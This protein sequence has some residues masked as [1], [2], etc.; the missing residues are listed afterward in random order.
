M[1]ILEVSHRGGVFDKIIKEA[2]EDLRSV[3]SIPSNYKVIFF[4]GGGTAQFA[5]VPLNLLGPSNVPPDYLITG[6]WSQ[7]AYNEAKLYCAPQAACDS[8]NSQF[9]TIPPS[10]SWVQNPKAPYI[11]YC[12]NETV[13]GIEFSGIPSTLPGVPLVVDM[14]S[15][16]LS[17]PVDVSKFGAIYAGAQKNC[18]MSG[19]T[20]VIVREDLLDI[21][22]PHP[23][24]TILNWKKNSSLGSC[25]NTPPTMAIYVAGLVFK[26]ILKEGGLTEMAARSKQ[27]SELLYSTIDQ[28]NGFYIPHVEPNSRS[29]MNVV[30]TIKNPSLLNKFIKEAESK[31]LHGLAGHRSVGG[32]RASLYNAVTLPQVQQLTTFMKQ[33]QIENSN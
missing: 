17:R 16:F 3:L 13:D 12:D 15:N 28:S 4:Q 30:F 2:E 24:P 5:S 26:W 20:I 23:I 27:K 21:R 19:V 14:S 33:F 25:L 10:T 1:S 22:S 29:R 9:V 11:F 18:G 31:G 6:K 32:L 8:P 7:S